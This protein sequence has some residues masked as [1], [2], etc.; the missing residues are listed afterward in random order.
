MLVPSIIESY[1][2]YTLLPLILLHLKN[3]FEGLHYET[4]LPV[5]D[6]LL[7]WRR[8]WDF[9]CLNMHEIQT[10]GDMGVLIGLKKEQGVSEGNHCGR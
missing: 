7:L 4:R 10:Y 1:R 3:I 5:S 6:L 9:Y 8:I 2:D